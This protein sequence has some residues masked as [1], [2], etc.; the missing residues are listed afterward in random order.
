MGPEWAQWLVGPISH[1]ATASERREYLG[2]TSDEDAAAFEERFWEARGPNVEWPPSGPRITFD[3]RLEE[4]DKK[5]SEGPVRGHR[6][7]RG[8]IW[9]LHGEPKEIRFEIPAHGRGE[10]IEIWKYGKKAEEG[11]DGKRPEANYY[12]RKVDGRTRFTSLRARSKLPGS[13]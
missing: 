9:V 2:L 7:D 6:T 8:I 12:F 10:P 3:Q 1:L 11:I 4:A 5:F 13:F